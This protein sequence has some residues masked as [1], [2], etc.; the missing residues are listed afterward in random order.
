MVRAGAAGCTSGEPG[1]AN[2][3]RISRLPQARRFVG[4]RSRRPAEASLPDSLPQGK[5]VTPPQSIVLVL[6]WSHN[7]VATPQRRGFRGDLVCQ[8]NRRRLSP[9]EAELMNPEQKT[10][11]TRSPFRGRTTGPSV[12]PR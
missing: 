1:A 4:S 2:G 12:M 11:I 7:S 3:L 6:F 9:A 8:D 5:S 10:S